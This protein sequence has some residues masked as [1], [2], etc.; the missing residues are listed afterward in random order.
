MKRT[1]YERIALAAERGT[2]C[3]L[4]AEEVAVLADDHAIQSRAVMDAEMAQLPEDEREHYE[5]FVPRGQA[6]ISDIGTCPG[7][8]WYRCRECGLYIEL[9]KVRS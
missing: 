9:G 4:S 3:R 1:P 2:G 5:C 6:P 7:D 8:G